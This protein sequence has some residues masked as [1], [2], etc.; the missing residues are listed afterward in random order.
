M[1]DRATSALRVALPMLFYGAVLAIPAWLLHAPFLAPPLGASI[2][3]CV[4]ARNLPPA[5]PHR[6]VIS[7]LVAV[8]CG[9]LSRFL[10]DVHQSGFA[11]DVVG[12]PSFFAA[13]V[14]I[15]MTGL[16]LEF[17]DAFHPPAAATTL[18]V[19]YGLV[20]GFIPESYIVLA[21]VLLALSKVLVD[22]MSRPTVAIQGAP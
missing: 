11:G 20:D 5:A 3:V 19:A 22:R 21:A 7:H 4:R 17:V 10:F 18:V 6:I 16:V 9:N 13:V 12:M 2:Y 8:L 14:A 1:I 15:A